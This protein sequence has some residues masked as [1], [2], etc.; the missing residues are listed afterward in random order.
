LIAGTNYQRYFVRRGAMRGR[1]R[2]FGDPEG[3]I[4]RHDGEL[5][6]RGEAFQRDHSG[7]RSRRGVFPRVDL[8]AGGLRGVRRR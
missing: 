1:Y 8:G 6:G 3:P 5:S 7:A 2:G 4:G